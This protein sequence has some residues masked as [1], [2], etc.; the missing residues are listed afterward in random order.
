IIVV[1]TGSADNTKKIAQAFGAKIF[2]F[3]WKN[4]FSAARNFSIEK[5]SGDWILALDADE[6]ITKKD[7]ERIR[8]IIAS[9]G[10]D[11]WGFKL[12][13]RNYTH[14]KNTADLHL[15][16]GEY[17]KQE[18]DFIGYT[19][20]KPVRLFRNL[21]RVRYR[22]NVHEAVEPSILEANKQ[23][24]DTAI[25]IHH[26]RAKK[27]MQAEKEKRESYVPM[28]EEMLKEKPKDPKPYYDL[29]LMYKEKGEFDKAMELFQKA[30]SLNPLYRNPFSNIAEIYM[31]KKQLPKAIEYLKKGMEAKP[32]ANDC[33]NLAL[34][35][36]KL[37]R[38][39]EAVDLL[40]KAIDLNPSQI[41]FYI[42]LASVYI[43]HNQPMK[44][45][46]LME[47]CTQQNPKNQDAWNFLG[48]FYFKAKQLEK[49]LGAFKKGMEANPEAKTD[50]NIKLHINLAKSYHAK[51]EYR[52]TIRVLQHLMKL[53]PLAPELIKKRIK[54]LQ[55]KIKPAKAS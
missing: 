35:Y 32:N 14:Q 33:Y 45:M 5:A 24:D 15:A 55:G 28:A 9:S 23:I 19:L 34:L 17:P 39:K 4:D 27:G 22:Y 25:I 26:Y 10:E 41:G 46:K 29:A 50:T 52:E 12:H 51:R 42:T 1:D 3:P 6:I 49:A 7:G 38:D 2:D 47:I 16:R 13:Q 18:G 40:R 31:R 30:I 8:K 48:L 36:T 37:G 43:A 21:P 53:D 54:E 44:A 11:V 20:A